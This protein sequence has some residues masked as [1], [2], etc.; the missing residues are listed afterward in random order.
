MLREPRVGLELG[1]P[2]DR[3]GRRDD[4]GLPLQE[5]GACV[6]WVMGAVCARACVGVGARCG[7][8]G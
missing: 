3:L 2:A 8:K 1:Q 5:G 4:R 7:E 6:C